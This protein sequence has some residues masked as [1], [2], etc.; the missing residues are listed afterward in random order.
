MAAKERGPLRALLLLT[1]GGVLRSLVGGLQPAHPPLLPGQPFLMLWGIPDTLCE[2]RPDPSAFGMVVKGGGAT[3]KF[4][5]FYPDTLGLYPY[6]DLQDQPVAGGLPQHSSLDMHLLKVEA[7]VTAALP[8]PDYAG[9]AAIH[10]EEWA[11]QWSRNRGKREIYQQQSR[12]LLRQFFPDWTPAELDKWAQVDFEA[13]AQAVLLETLQEAR[14]LRPQA[15][16]GFSPYPDCYNSGPG[17]RLANYSGCCP[18]AEMALNDEM[19]WLWKK[20][21]A[22]YPSLSLDKLVGGTQGARLYSSNQIREALRVAALAG[23][24]YDLPVF[25]LVKSVYSSTNTFL[26]E[27]S[28]SRQGSAI[29][30]QP[31]VTSIIY[32]LG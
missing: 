4:A 31:I 16:W 20:S 5:I 13:A 18:A 19:L 12:Q 32:S 15:L 14:N 1:L 25:P 22:L 11:P 2:G 9:L 6:Y 28:V 27:V 26:S 8:P 17:Q 23:T 30:I 29:T 3:Q 10:W 7:D 21:A 24:A